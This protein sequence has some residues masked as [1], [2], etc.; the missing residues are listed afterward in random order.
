MNELPL[1]KTLIDDLQ[2]GRRPLSNDE[3]LRLAALL[4][5]VETPIPDLYSL[6]AIQGANR[7]WTSDYV[8]LYLGIP[9]E[10]YSPGLIEPCSACIIGHAEPDSPIALDYRTNPPRVVYFSDDGYWL[11]LCPSY[12]ALISKISTDT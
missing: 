1:P 6:D 11:E 3:K 7:L 8:G 10:E 2:S 12:E 5:A 9:S 4:Q